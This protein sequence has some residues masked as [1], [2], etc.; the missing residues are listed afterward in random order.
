M[1]GQVKAVNSLGDAGG[2]LDLVGKV[3]PAPQIHGLQQNGLSGR[4]VTRSREYIGVSDA[5]DNLPLGRGRGAV[6]G[7]TGQTEGRRVVA[8]I[9]QAA[10]LNLPPDEGTEQRA[11]GSWWS[12]SLWY[13]ALV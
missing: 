8:G 4:M 10:Q 5:L 1:L 3:V 7:V 11:A 12:A 9:E 13:D 2:T 6:H